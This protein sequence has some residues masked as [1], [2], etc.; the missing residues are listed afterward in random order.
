MLSG[1][2]TWSGWHR[3]LFLLGLGLAA[4]VA[5]PS[6]PEGSGGLPTVA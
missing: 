5:A 3:R 2:V 4:K 6:Q 1:A